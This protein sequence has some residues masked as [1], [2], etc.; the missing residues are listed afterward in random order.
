MKSLTIIAVKILLI[1]FFTIL[2]SELPFLFA[3]FT[4]LKEINHTTISYIISLFIRVWLIISF[5]IY[6]DKI[7]SYILDTFNEQKIN[8]ETIQKYNP[9]HLYKIAFSI[10]GI[11]ILLNSFSDFSR[12]TMSFTQTPIRQIPWENLIRFALSL[13][14]GL[15][16]IFKNYI[17]INIINSD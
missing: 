4:D 5:W 9:I 7:S 6:A 12:I 14:L 3:F 8:S 1:Y 10:A 17:I 15:F 16:L 13:I 2:A 11:F